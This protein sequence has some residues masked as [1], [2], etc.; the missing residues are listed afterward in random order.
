VADVSFPLEDWPTYAATV[1]LVLDQP[2][3]GPETL[4]T[5]GAE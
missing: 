3:A 4:G 5:G 1:D 2:C